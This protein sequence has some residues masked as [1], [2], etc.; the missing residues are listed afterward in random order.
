MSA[1]PML[2]E[3]DIYVRAYDIDAMGYVNNIVYVRW[4]ED[5]RHAFLDKYFPFEKMIKEQKSPVI[6]KT[7]V[8]YLKPLNIHSKPQ[9]RAWMAKMGKTKWTM[10]L[11]IVCGDDICCRG[12]QVGYFH[13]IAK[14]K[15]A[16][17][18]DY[19]LEAYD[20]DKSL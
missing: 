13:D 9:G 16:L 1:K 5:I 18:P 19:M 3:I 4:F 17:F 14:N 12:E 2:T 11:E 8:E 20:K 7:T 6:M 15:P 10:N